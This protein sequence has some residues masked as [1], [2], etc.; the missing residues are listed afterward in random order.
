MIKLI[1]C[2]I[3][4]SHGVET[5]FNESNICKI[6]PVS[7]GSNSFHGSRIYTNDG[8]NCIVASEPSVIYNLLTSPPRL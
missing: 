6:K 3:D 8:N 4:G 7:N 1:E 5:Y 2:E